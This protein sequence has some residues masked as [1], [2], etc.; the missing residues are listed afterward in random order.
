MGN[1]L[2]FGS[3]KFTPELSS[4][5]FYKILA[6]CPAQEPRYLEELDN[7]WR[8]VEP[9]IFKSEAPYTQLGKPS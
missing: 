5:A 4:E 9:E 7:L 1:Y 8:F 6:S 3:K 2:S